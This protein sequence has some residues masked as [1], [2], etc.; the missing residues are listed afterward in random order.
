MSVPSGGATINFATSSSISPGN[1]TLNI[2]GTA[3]GATGTASIPLAVVSGTPN[4]LGF[5]I[6]QYVEV[7]LTQGGSTSIS[8]QFISTNL[9]NPTYEVTLGAKGLPPGVTASFSPQIVEAGGATD[10][11]FTVTLTASST[12]PPVSNAPFSIVAT[13]SA[14][15]PATTMNFLLDLTAAGGGA[16]WSNQTSYVST[17]A[18]SFA[19][20]Y[21]PVH[22]LIY[23][24]NNTWNRIDI[25]SDKTRAIVK[26][27]SIQ[28]PVGIDISLDGSTVWVTTD[29]QV[30]Y[31]I[32]TTSFQATRYILPRYGI[33]STSVGSSWLG[34]KVFS[35]ADGTVLLIFGPTA[36][37][38]QALSESAIWNPATGSFTSQVPPAA[39]GAVARS[40]D[41]TRIF[42]F[43]SDEFG[44]S[45]T[46]DVHSGTFSNAI[47]L[48]N[49]GYATLA[50]ASNDGSKVAVANGS[51]ALYD[52]NLNEI[53]PLPGDGGAGSFSPLNLFNGGFVFS[54][55]GS[56]IYE[57]TEVT[58]IP[59][60]VSI[61][62]TTLEATATSP[63][64][65]VIPTYVR[66]SPPYYI[67]LPFAVDANG[68]ILGLQY[69]GISFD[70]STVNFNYSV[71]N[72]GTPTYS[73]FASPFEGPL[74]GGTQSGGFNSFVL[75]PDV[76]YGGVKGTAS[77]TANDLTFVSPPAAQP[78][79]VNLKFLFPDGME[80]FD[81]QSFT[82]G[83]DLQDAIISGGS[84]QGGVAAKL[85]GFGLPVNIS[86][87]TL[88]VGGNA[89]TVTATPTPTGYLPPFT[90]EQTDMFLSYVSPSGSPGWADLTVTSPDGTSTLPKSFFFAKSVNDYATTDS[91]TF[92]LYDKG[93]NQ[94]YLSAGSHI[95]VFSL[96]SNSF[97]TPF[98][99]P[100]V[101]TSK[102][103]QG[104]AL[105]PDGK[106]L[107]AADLTD[108]SLAVIDP[109]N[110]SNAIAI[111]VAT[112]GA[113]VGY[114]CPTGPLFVAADNLGNA[115]VV[116]G[117]VI[118]TTACGP[119]GYEAVIN[120]GSKTST[121]MKAAGCD[122]RGYGG[123]LE[124]SGDG[125]LIAIT[126]GGGSGS[127]QLY[128]PAQGSCTPAATPSTQAQGFGVTVA[129]DGNV[130]GAVSTFVN[131][132][133]NI[134]GRLAYPLVYYPNTNNEAYFAYSPF[135][136]GA[137]Q[138]PA[139]NDPGSLYYWAYPNYIDI[140]DV[141][142]GT[143]ALRFGLTETVANTVSPMAIDS[144]GQRIFLV[145]NK[146]LTVVDLG[147]APLSV[148][149]FSQTSA[150]PGNQ[151]QV[152][153]S[154]F[155]NGVTATLGGIGASLTFTDS[156]TLI[157]TIPVSNSGP[158][159]LVLT[160]PDGTTYTLQ[161]AITVQ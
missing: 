136:D 130:V 59:V 125:T 137:L 138:N 81:P 93:R 7:Q 131:A 151:I 159:D 12:A 67:S 46:Y 50:A 17:R 105:T 5:T 123:Y 22:T 132:S 156:E 103:F 96:S 106:Y 42:S 139:L 121:L 86:Q 44:T 128:A 57:E 16:G 141:Q 111:P 149:H 23:S 6:P 61:S 34:A 158:E 13:P 29:S 62:T 98:Q 14:D 21:D 36:Y 52:G 92:L 2:S 53:G 25:I 4:Q 10:Q 143:P 27:L 45:F 118:G 70:D 1:L 99:P 135:Q 122:S 31:G 69:H 20:V 148:G 117:G 64:M 58:P 94:V 147:N 119:G 157:L 161:N 63:A 48:P 65:P 72:P 77:L 129:A 30:I 55:D 49:S 9:N 40:G 78:G 3:G 153:G 76:Y 107:L 54:P 26:S 41:G 47:Q 145:T 134:V 28:D 15:V 160:N 90:G 144:S 43:G 102:Q 74:Q 104:L 60:I 127:F 88:T 68:M 71:I 150:S 97:A 82:Y 89:A 38:Q 112:G 152:R 126:G 85:D 100:A 19:A 84:P 115:Y 146:G 155:E 114:S 91:P 32:N 142:H 101:G 133:G 124:A 83:V 73:N 24:A 8:S 33:T 140:V 154:G 75:T 113:S 116:T 66:L 39:W 18:N 108:Y 79:P 56:T 95:D 110:P 35:L 87:D 80:I 37:D 109:D 11:S 120:L 51:F